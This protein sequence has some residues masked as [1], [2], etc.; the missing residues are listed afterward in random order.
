MIQASKRRDVATGKLSGFAVDLPEGEGNY[1]VVDDICDG[2]G[3]FMGLADAAHASEYRAT[4]DLFVTHGVF[5]KG[6]G[7]LQTRYRTVYTTN[8]TKFDKGTATVL[9]AVTDLLNR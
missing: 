3:T 6:V 1:L 5:S 7:P 4:L 9:N 8:S 2:G